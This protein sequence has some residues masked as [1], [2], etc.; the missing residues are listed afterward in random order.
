MVPG[1]YCWIDAGL[2]WALIVR[3]AAWAVNC[4]VL[5][6]MTLLLPLRRII[7]LYIH[8]M[9]WAHINVRAGHFRYPLILARNTWT[10]LSCY[11][12]KLRKGRSIQYWALDWA[13]MHYTCNLWKGWRSL[14][15]IQTVPSRNRS[16]SSADGTQNL[17]SEETGQLPEW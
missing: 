11:R 8:G 12:K 4:L 14:A 9:C 17:S 10:A 13:E 3:H 15:K 6:T 16:L 5:P 2:S 1:P 7:D